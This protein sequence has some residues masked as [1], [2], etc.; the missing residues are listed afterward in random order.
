M[1]KLCINHA[2]DLPTK[3]KSRSTQ[4]NRASKPR[5][6]TSILGRTKQILSKPRR[7]S[8]LPTTRVR[9][10]FR[11]SS[12][13]GCGR[14]VQQVP[15]SCVVY[16]VLVGRRRVLIRVS[17]R[18]AVKSRKTEGKTDGQYKNEHYVSGSQ[19]QFCTSP[20]PRVTSAC[21]GP[22]HGK[23]PQGGVSFP[24]SC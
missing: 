20:F 11:E 8:P 21:N 6:T 16:R 14:T 17:D 18:S 4:Q 2:T 19:V 15:K 24:I 13:V 9:P 10:R 1:Q 22:K 12:S 5:N 7:R 23:T 3:I